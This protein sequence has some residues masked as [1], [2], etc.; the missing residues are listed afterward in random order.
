[1]RLDKFIC[2]S[3]EMSRNEAKKALR[4]GQIKVDGNVVK[5]ST[6]NVEKTHEV[7]MNGEVLT[8]IG[9]RYIMLHKPEETVCSNVD[10][11]YPS[12]LNLIDLPK[13]FE[14][15]IAGRLDAD[16]TGLVILT[17]DGQWAHKITSPRHQCKKVYRVVLKEN[18]TTAMKNT[19]EQGV[20][21]NNEHGLTKPA[22]VQVLSPR[23]ILLTICE[24]KYH[25]VKRM[26][27]A[28]GNKVLELHRQQIG[29]IVLDENVAEGQWRYLTPQEVSNLNSG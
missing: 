14:L 29:D 22:I 9:I 26:L 18:M 5:S 19:L 23:E 1:M 24:G 25:Q 3:S 11:V 6:F 13:A 17:D 16:T 7:T 20:Q 10:E 8:L 4:Y 12:V 15:T 2:K 28:V 21:L 27:A